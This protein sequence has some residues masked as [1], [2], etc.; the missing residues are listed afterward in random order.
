MSQTLLQWLESRYPTAKRQNFRRWV[1]A[2]SITVDGKAARRLTQILSPDA[3]VERRLNRPNSHETQRIDPRLHIVHQD[4]DLLVVNKPAGLL[5]STTARERRTTLLALVRQFIDTAATDSDYKRDPPRAKGAAPRS[6]PAPRVG[7]RVG[8]IHRLDRDAAGLLVFSLNELAYDSLKSQF[9]HHTV[10]RQY[11]AIVQPPPQQSRGRFKSRLVE[12]ADGTVYSTDEPG[13][14]QLAI[15]EYE[16]VSQSKNRALLRVTLFTGRKHQ[17][18]VHLSERGCPI[19][20][21]SVYGVDARA[22]KGGKGGATDRTRRG[23]TASRPAEDSPLRLAAVLLA[24]DHPRTGER[25]TF[26]AAP[27]W[28]VEW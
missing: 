4:Q 8:L 27:P 17:I 13:K 23:G 7:P 18:R 24:F 26:E 16:V 20:G 25:L 11:L 2:G 28:S 6:R 14:G 5:T 15:T 10:T 12:R 21:D 19:V 3:Q 9:F 1:A 22:A